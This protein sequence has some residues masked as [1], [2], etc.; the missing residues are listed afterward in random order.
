MASKSKKK[1]KQYRK[2]S[3]K[4]KY[5]NIQDFY[6]YFNKKKEPGPFEIQFSKEW[7]W[8]SAKKRRSFV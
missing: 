6:Y 2:Q 5:K 1:R 3:L 4:R 7:K 8:R